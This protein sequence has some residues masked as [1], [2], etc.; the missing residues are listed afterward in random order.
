MRLELLSYAQQSK[1][2]TVDGQPLLWCAV[3]KTWLA[4]QPEEYVRQGLILFLVELDYPINLMQV[5]RKVGST[6]DRLDLLV[7]DRN[8][9]P[10]VLI[11]VK[12]PG[13]K[14]QPAVEQL[15]RYNRHWKAPFT[16]AINGEEALCY[17]V[18]WE[19]E[20]IHQVLEIPRFPVDKN[21][22]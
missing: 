17:A 1:T 6:N 9:D 2:K 4:A 11:E 3:R 12:A 19:K 22:P 5:E 13:L 20:S 16:L 15:A 10:F 14:L 8:H 21:T 7:L 18:D